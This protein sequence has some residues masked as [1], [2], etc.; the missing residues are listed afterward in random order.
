MLRN[1]TY[2]CAYC[3]GVFCFINDDE[4]NKDKVEKEY[5]LEF[6]QSSKKNRDIV[7]DDCWNIVKP[8]KGIKDATP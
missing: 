1:S 4:W 6:P 3:G 7:C 2:V 8:T 5:E